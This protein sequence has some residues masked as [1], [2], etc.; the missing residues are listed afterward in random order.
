ML[1]RDN[2][3]IKSLVL[4]FIKLPNETEWLEFKQDNKDPNLIGQYISA[5]SNSAALNNKPNAYVIWGI[6]D[7]THKI[8]GTT[9]KPS[10]EKR[11]NENLENWLLRLLEPKIDYKFHEISIEDKNV[12]LLE[13][14]SA[15][16]RPVSFEGKEYI[17]F[18]EN[19][20]KLR[21]LPEKEKELWRT[22]DKT[23]FEKQISADNISVT[24]ILNLL[25]S[26]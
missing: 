2:E 25:E 13:I 4:E 17:R 3:Y 19:K 24:D 20:K 10:M 23:P 12:V 22:F 9:F 8:I 6:D 14:V 16:K 26:S 5:L 15:D 11:G 7:K 18:G 1:T 21:E